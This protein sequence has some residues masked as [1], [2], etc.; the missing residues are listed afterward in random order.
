M[1]ETIK[2]SIFLALALVFIGVAVLT[3][4][5]V[6]EIKIE[7]QVGKALFPK[8]TS[9]LDIKKLEI[10]R[11]NEHGG[12][13][14]FRIVEVDGVW[15]IPSHENYPADAEDQMGRVAEPFVD[16][17]V[18]EVVDP[19]KEGGDPAAIHVLYG[20]VDPTSQDATLEEGVGLRVTFTGAEEETLVDL[21]VGKK[22]GDVDADSD[23]L[24][25]NK[26]SLHYVR[27]AGQSPIYIVEIDPSRFVT[28]FDQWIE[29]NLLDISTFDMRGVFVDEYSF[30]TKTVLMESNGVLVPQEEI[31]PRFIGDITLS[32]DATAMGSE[33]W[34][35]D[36]QMQFR[37]RQFEIYEEMPLPRDRE[38]NPEKLDEMV[39]A[40]NDLKIVDVTKKPAS[41]AAWLRDGKPLD[42]MAHDA[43][44]RKSGFF[45]VQIPDLKGGS[46]E[47]RLQLLSSRGDMQIRMKDGIRYQ[48]RFG[49]LSGPL[50]ETRG[51]VDQ[52]SMNANRF[53]FI[54]A[55]FD[56]SAVAAPDI[57]PPLD[58]AEDASE[59]TR[60]AAKEEQDRIEKSNQRE[61][62]RHQSEI[63]AGHQRAEKLNARFADWYYV[64]SE[65]VYKKI[66]LTR[67]NIF[68]T[69]TVVPDE[70]T[71][72]PDWP[73]LP[74]F[75][76]PFDFVP[77]NGSTHEVPPASVPFD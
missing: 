47:T 32:Y 25:E 53:L 42:E 11:L 68:R 66:H 26:Q 56:E 55:D 27:V 64:I 6:T 69:K 43:S 22:A 29:S 39:A 73:E 16:L 74:R 71:P 49:D 38:L 58:I 46:T 34:R 63:E 59:E 13:T 4:P 21:I 5:I 33:K 15:S 30:S 41:L 77:K 3:R 9:P 57:R 54:T 76:E 35:L 28:D 10:V 44:L 1:N 14:D 24:P 37:G 12:R 60:K 61:R 52:D 40:L 18:L 36:K 67:D 23:L 17:R 31:M 8:F 2:T 70:E 72:L 48:L 50:S 7:D 20:V 45:I 62:E 51:E 65:D 75:D 19:I